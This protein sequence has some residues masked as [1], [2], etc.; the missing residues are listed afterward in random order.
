MSRKELASTL[1]T[2]AMTVALS[3]YVIERT[4]I[5]GKLWEP[6][7]VVELHRL[8]RPGRVAIDVGA[9][10]RQPREVVHRLRV[11]TT[12]TAVGSGGERLHRHH[13]QPVVLAEPSG[14]RNAA[15]P[16]SGAEVLPG[17]TPGPVDEQ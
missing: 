7:V 3:Y 15:E 6:D 2:G 13:A 1:G 16:A 17:R 14:P 11:W 10:A 9:Q 5:D 12:A 4:L 8:L